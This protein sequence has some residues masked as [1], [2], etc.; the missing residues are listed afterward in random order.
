MAVGALF[1][2]RLC[3]IIVA[4]FLFLE[5]F[6]FC[7][8]WFKVLWLLYSDRLCCWFWWKFILVM[9]CFIAFVFLSFYHST[10]CVVLVGQVAVKWIVLCF[11][12]ENILTSVVLKITN[13]F[14]THIDHTNDQFWAPLLDPTVFQPVLYAFL[15]PWSSPRLWFSQI[16]NTLHFPTRS[17]LGTR[18]I[19]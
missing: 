12:T 9:I 17:F 13:I 10:S 5:M 3:H 8:V 7:V 15:F 4:Q 6:Y 14:L 11:Y 19:L 1:Q 16:Q 2:C 18:F